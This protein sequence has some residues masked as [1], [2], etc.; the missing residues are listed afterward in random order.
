MR[1]KKFEE[2]LY[3]T[4]EYVKCIRELYRSFIEISQIYYFLID[5]EFIEHYPRFEKYY[6]KCFKKVI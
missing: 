5:H 2:I 3:F 6:G 1:P 4:V